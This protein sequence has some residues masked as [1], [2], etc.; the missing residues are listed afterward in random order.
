MPTRTLAVLAALTALTALAGEP[1]GVQ[2][3]IEEARARCQA[4]EGGTLTVADAAIVPTDL[5]GDGAPDAVVD[6][7]GL[8]CS[9]SA[10]LFCGGTGGCEI[11]LVAEGTVTPR[12]AKGWRVVDWAGDRI[13]LLQVHGSA[14][15]GTNLRRCYEALVW[16]EGAFRSLRVPG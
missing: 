7:Q 13:V 15:G 1:A 8:R 10:S 2:G 16:S 6:G 4:F 11:A 5:T 12:L 14:C 9:S 3:V